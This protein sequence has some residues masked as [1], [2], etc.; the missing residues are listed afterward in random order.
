MARGMEEVRGGSG[1]VSLCEILRKETFCIYSTIGGD[2]P[3]G[4]YHNTCLEI[5][6]LK[7]KCIYNYGSAREG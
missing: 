5:C 1:V 7:E 3:V 4:G 2:G 6:N